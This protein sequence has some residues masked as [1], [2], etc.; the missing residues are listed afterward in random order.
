MIRATLCGLAVVWV[1][2]SPKAFGQVLGGPQ[3][4]S[5]Y[6]LNPYSNP[7][8]NMNAVPLMITPNMSPSQSR[9]L[10]RMM[11][12]QQAVPAA[13]WGAPGLR[14]PAPSVKRWGGMHKPDPHDAPESPANPSKIPGGRSSKYFRPV[15][16]ALGLSTAPH[17]YFS[18]GRV[19][20]RGPH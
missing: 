2:S 10:L 11:A 5:P 6:F 17:A 9:S 7:P 16:S 8:V 12:T 13:S 14:G 19:N 20:P 18:R 4:V 15:G 1:L 3:Y